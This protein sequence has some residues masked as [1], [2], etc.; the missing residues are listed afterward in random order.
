MAFWYYLS[1]CQKF[2]LSNYNLEIFRNV[3]HKVKYDPKGFHLS[4]YNPF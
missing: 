2:K 3:P 1:C 4:R